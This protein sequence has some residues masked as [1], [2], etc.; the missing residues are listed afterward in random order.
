MLISGIIRRIFTIRLRTGKASILLVL[1]ALLVTSCMP[2]KKTAQNF[3]EK[4]EN[5]AVMIVPP[6]ASFLY[7]Y[8]YEMEP[9]QETTSDGENIDQSYFLSRVDVS[10][11]DSIF[12]TS[13]Q[14]NLAEYSVRV[15]SPDAYDRFLSFPG[16]RFIFTMA[17]TELVESDYP[18]VDRALIDTILYRQEFLLRAVERNTWFEFIEVDDQ[19]TDGGM[20][21]LF[22]TFYTSDDVS[23]RF[24]YRGFTGEML[25]EY[26][27]YIMDLQDVY[28]LQEFAGNGNARYIFEFLLN[29]HVQ[30]NASPI[31]GSP[32]RFRYN[33]RTGDISRMPEGMEFILLEASGQPEE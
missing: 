16:K 31:V 32:V 7:Y 19:E 18:H 4:R 5:I 9:E 10:V 24:R 11:A 29:R 17:Q 30:Q 13:L 20:E 26:S 14:E 33:I 15:F 2:G 12:L 6:P 25:Y 1:P 27:S 28:S 8:P 21:V 3:L 22:S 23:G